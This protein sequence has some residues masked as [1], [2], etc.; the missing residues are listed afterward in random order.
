MTKS[1][2]SSPLSSSWAVS[3]QTFEDRNAYVLRNLWKTFYQF[4]KHVT[5]RF[6]TSLNEITQ[7]AP[8]F[9]SGKSGYPEGKKKLVPQK[10]NPK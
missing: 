10:R 7:V 1:I 2:H 9:L 3:G 8:L 5:G 6:I 4:A